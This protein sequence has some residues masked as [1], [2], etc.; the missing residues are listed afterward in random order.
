[1]AD[2][3]ALCDTSEPPEPDSADG[4]IA[5][6]SNGPKD[7]HSGRGEGAPTDRKSTRRS[8]RPQEPVLQPSL[9]P[10]YLTVD[11]VL[12]AI[13]AE[14]I[15]VR[16]RAIRLLARLMSSKR[17]ASALGISV[18][19]ALGRLVAWWLRTKDDPEAHRTPRP[20]EAAAHEV[21]S[22]GG[23]KGAAAAKA[24]TTVAIDEALV[25]DEATAMA[26][27][28]VAK[29]LEE[30]DSTRV[31]RDEALAYALTIMLELAGTGQDERAAIG[32]DSVVEL[33]ANVLKRLPCAPEE[34]YTNSGGHC[35]TLLAEKTAE[36]TAT[37]SVA[38]APASTPTSVA[39][40]IADKGAEN[41]GFQH[42]PSHGTSTKPDT[43]LDLSL[44]RRPQD[45]SNPRLLCCWRGEK[46]RD[47][48]IGLF[49]P[50]D[51]G[52]DF[53]VGENQ[54]PMQPGLI[55]RAAALRVLLVVV[56][57][58]DP[59]LEAATACESAALA[60]TT[61]SK[62][63]GTATTVV[64]SAAVASALAAGAK[65]VIK[66]A[67]PVCV[68]LLSVDMRH[69]ADDFGTAI[70]FDGGE[71][72]RDRT[73]VDRDATKLTVDT[74]SGIPVSPPEELVHEEI[75]LVCL[76]LL[77]S[78]LRLGGFAREALLFVADTH[79]NHWRNILE[80]EGST[81]AS[82][83]SGAPA[84][85]AKPTTKVVGKTG[86]KTEGGIGKEGSW[87]KPEQFCSWELRGKNE[88]QSMLAALPYIR[89]VSVFLLPLRNPSAPV[90]DI[91]AALTGLRRLCKEAE[92]EIGGT[93]PEPPGPNDG[94]PLLPLNREGTAGA[95]VD[96]LAGVAVSV[97]A[98][99]PLV[100]IWGCAVA[101]AGLGELK[102]K[103]TGMV[104][105]C[106]ALINYLICRGTA[107]E[108]FWSSL[109]SLEQIR[110][111]KE[112]AA[113]AEALKKGKRKSKGVGKGGKGDKGS[114]PLEHEDDSKMSSPPG[115]PSPAG[116]PD[117]NLGPNRAT[118]GKLLNTR[119]DEQR[120]QT[121][122]TTALLMATRTGLETAI[123]NLILAGAD[124]NVRGSDG[125]SSLMCALA[126][127][128]DEAVR[129][130]VE[131][132]ADV[133]AV[134]V[135]GS[136]VLKWAFLCPSRR[137]MRKTMQK[138][139][140][141]RVAEPAAQGSGSTTRTDCS[142]VDGQAS[143][144]ERPYNRTRTGSFS[145]SRGRSRSR[146]GSI[147]KERRR[148][149]LSRS[150]SFSGNSVSAAAAGSTDRRRLSRMSSMSAADSARAALREFGRRD[151]FGP[152][153]TPRGTTVIRGDARMVPFILACGADPNVSSGTGD[154]PLHWA[155][156]GTDDTLWVMNQQVRI[157]T[158]GDGGDRS[159]GSGNAQDMDGSQAEDTSDVQ[160]SKAQLEGAPLGDQG[161]KNS[162]LDEQLLLLK[163][164]V[165][166]GSNLDSCNPDGITALHAAVIAGRT[167]LA[168]ALLDAGASPNISDNLGCLPLHYACI[169][170]TC[171]YANLAKRLLAL[172]M[173][174]PLDEG[175]H[176]DDRKVRV[177]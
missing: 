73:A 44:T 124:P 96:T 31:L 28:I 35:P 136:S 21:K 76:K 13:A 94:V 20:P 99:V 111:M 110:E 1:M 128:M 129:G 168:G 101:A 149:S 11:A 30:S 169:R 22:T 6:G 51:W 100:S 78:L 52:W 113:E 139:P 137:T 131:A 90:T 89:T 155:V 4:S 98:L 115:P 15:D 134:D 61:T 40:A 56:E 58:Y 3:R 80:T 126:Q 62:G 171:G 176:R 70:A 64:G 160:A 43:S 42:A 55:L 12:A 33:L 121:Q 118:W 36:A 109:L 162:K 14:S 59:A 138:G 46:S 148:S 65:S 37:T 27:K 85:P 173:G 114:L 45:S 146:S 71:T 67:L 106:Q 66:H 165:G 17:C 104:N 170:S 32:V 68:D 34:F 119:V 77:G 50:L 158:G 24:A 53:E 49:S 117:P 39:A 145:G 25:K 135:Y 86:S 88:A 174:R 5:T 103:T 164:L 177:L 144:G 147:S 143:L 172:G 163:V 9:G 91:M 75:R 95:L 151:S 157:I 54:E 10:A 152:L 133:D 142:S 127:G 112:A 47:P 84:K 102:A 2:D 79:R 130:L 38:T 105:E 8:S 69:S 82:P 72:S 7:T 108:S 29:K 63:G 57:G 19:P 26:E 132:G 93:Q 87:T 154:F 156:V 107:R 123:S 120:T 23:K 125:R 92:Y 97:G 150:V 166:A 41:E 74:L 16:C 18:V 60:S 122:G 141:N 140:Q 153:K 116:R 161:G 159:A 81:L 83:E 167:A 48:E 175:V